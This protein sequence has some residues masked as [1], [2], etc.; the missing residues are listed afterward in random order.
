MNLK[1]GTDGKKILFVANIDA[2]IN[3]N[4]LMSLPMPPSIDRDAKQRNDTRKGDGHT[5]SKMSLACSAFCKRLVSDD[6]KIEASHLNCWHSFCS[7]DI[8]DDS[9][10]GKPL[11]GSDLENKASEQSDDTPIVAS[12]AGASDLFQLH[13]ICS[14]CFQ[15]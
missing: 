6:Q 8:D 9:V 4:V 7:D 11:P 5:H 14:S 13:L 10:P 3:D 15:L 12:N 1:N 2:Q